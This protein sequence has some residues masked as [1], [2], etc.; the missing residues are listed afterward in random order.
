MKIIPEEKRLASEF[1][2]NLL[3]GY[4]TEDCVFENHPVFAEH[5]NEKYVEYFGEDHPKY[6]ENHPL[7][8]KWYV[9]ML[10]NRLETNPSLS[11]KERKRIQKEITTINE[12][13]NAK[14]RDGIQ[15]IMKSMI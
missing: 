4:G 12:M 11:R 14:I 5:A 2:K 1:V 3:D 10:E 13:R 6:V 7:I 15:K 9:E 8:C